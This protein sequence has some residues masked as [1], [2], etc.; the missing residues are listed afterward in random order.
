MDKLKL[1]IIKFPDRK[2]SCLSAYD[3]DKNIFYPLAYFSNN[4]RKELFLKA[5]KG[6]VRK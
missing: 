5:L 4:Q 6:S 2:C 3:E 1:K